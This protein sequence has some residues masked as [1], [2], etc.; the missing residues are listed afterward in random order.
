MSRT[1]GSRLPEPVLISASS[2]SGLRNFSASPFSHHILERK[3][4]R[5]DYC[6]KILWVS[7]AVAYLGK[8][9][10]LSGIKF[11]IQSLKTRI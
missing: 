7:Q 3:C 6:V 8:G 10:W 2:C 5:S 1:W 4:V 9:G 11:W